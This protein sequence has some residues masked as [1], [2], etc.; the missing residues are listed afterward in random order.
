MNNTKTHERKVKVVPPNNQE[1][2]VY[3]ICPTVTILVRD[4]KEHRLYLIVNP[5][6]QGRT[7][8][9]AFKATQQAQLVATYYH[10]DKKTSFCFT[11]GENAVSITITDK[12]F[13]EIRKAMGRFMD[14]SYPDKHSILRKVSVSIIVEKDGWLVRPTVRNQQGE[15]TITTGLSTPEESEKLKSYVEQGETSQFVALLEGIVKRSFPLF[16]KK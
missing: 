9:C 3:S 13:T 4:S 2:V 16:W 10:N 1:R 7:P 14:N 8:R 6:S 15:K 11:E 12:L 5:R